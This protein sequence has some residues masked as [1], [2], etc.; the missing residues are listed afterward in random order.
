MRMYEWDEAKNKSNQEKHGISF[1]E[2]T[3]ALEGFTLDKRDTRFDYHETRIISIAQTTYCLI[4]VVV[5]TDRVGRTRIISARKANKSE[6]E[7]YFNEF[8]EG[9]HD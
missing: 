8:K 5:H 9:Q 4:I 6:R 7:L 1:E 3:K 2:A